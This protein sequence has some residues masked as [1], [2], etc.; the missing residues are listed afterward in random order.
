YTSYV[1]VGDYGRIE[2]LMSVMA[3]AV[4]VIRGGANFGFIRFYFLDKAPE[5]RRR[6]IRTVFWA[7]VGY[8]TLALALCVISAAEIARGLNV[9]WRPGATLQDSGANLVVAT[10]ILLW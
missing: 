7:P 8:A 5:H 2:L 9:N 4:V 3:V 1:S 10:A 6:L